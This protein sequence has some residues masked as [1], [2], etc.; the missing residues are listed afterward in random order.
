MKAG[1]RRRMTK[2][3]GVVGSLVWDVI[4]GRDPASAPVEEWGGIAYALS[5]L[6]AHLPPDWEIVPLIKVGR[7]LSAEAARFMST[8]TAPRAGRTLHRGAGAE[9]PRGAPLPVH[10]APL[11]AHER[12]RAVVELGRAGPDGDGP[13]RAVRELHLRLRDVPGHRAGAPPGIQRSRSMPT[14]TASSSA[15]STTASARCSRSATRRPGSAAST[16]CR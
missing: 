5:S 13:R 11:R 9:Q 2:K 14:C 7:D 12:R 1:R 16:W 6:D 3:L 15:C 8:L 10:R 4:H